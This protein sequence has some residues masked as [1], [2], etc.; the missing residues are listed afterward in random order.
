MYLQMLK[1]KKFPKCIFFSISYSF[2]NHSLW[3][4]LSSKNKISVF[5]EGWLQIFHNENMRGVQNVHSLTGKE[6]K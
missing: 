4:T 5:M 2:L 6:T 3:Y 1:Q